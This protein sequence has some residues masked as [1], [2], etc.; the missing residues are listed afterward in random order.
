MT[1]VRGGDAA[2]GGC[3]I[4]FPE[5]DVIGGGDGQAL[6]AHLEVVVAVHEEGNARSLEAAA[7]LR[8]IK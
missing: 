3:G 2:K 6:V 7:H 8:A 4:R 1:G 5:P